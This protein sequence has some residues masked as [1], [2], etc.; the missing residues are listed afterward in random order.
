MIYYSNLGRFESGVTSNFRDLYQNV[1]KFRDIDFGEVVS[2]TIQY[3]VSDDINLY[4]V[5][6]SKANC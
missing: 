1:Q 5:L 4:G 2:P 3:N 6:G